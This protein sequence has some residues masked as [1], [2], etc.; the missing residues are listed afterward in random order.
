MPV[1]NCQSASEAEAP[2]C[3]G[4]EGTFRSTGRPSAST[5]SSG[6][7]YDALELAVTDRSRASVIAINRRTTHI[8]C[9]QIDLQNTIVTMAFLSNMV[10]IVTGGG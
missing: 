6:Y 7:W 5:S 2:C 1:W 4:S 10:A 8:L 9:I 3:L